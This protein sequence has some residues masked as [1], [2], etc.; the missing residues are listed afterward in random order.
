M[1]GLPHLGTPTT[2][3][4][5]SEMN[6]ARGAPYWRQRMESSLPPAPPAGPVAK[7]AEPPDHALVPALAGD[8][9]AY[10]EGS[11]AASS[12][13][14]YDAAW[15]T[16]ASWCR[17][18][19]R[20]ELPATPATVA[21]YLADR[22]RERK[23]NTVA[24][25]MAA[26]SRAHQL[27]RE[28]NPVLDPGVRAVMSGIR[29]ALG[30]APRQV[31]PLLASDV[32]AILGLLADDLTGLRDRVLLLVGL[33]AATR[34]QELVGIDVEDLA[35]ANQG[36]VVNIKTS[37]TDQERKGALVG[38]AVG[39]EPATCPVV[40]VRTWMRESGVV[41][42]P[43][44][45]EVSRHG[46]VGER[47]LRPRAVYRLVRRLGAL[48]GLDPSTLGGHSLRAGFATS[49]AMQGVPELEIAEV[50]RHRSVAVLR[51]YVRRATVLEHDLT[52]RLGL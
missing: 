6:I 19:G 37:K 13:A 21:S 16:F 3:A 25:E 2:R 52:R 48:V 1:S 22:A 4:A 35:F 34:Q 20:P 41:S 45:R 49:A 42:G 10:V 32:K 29:R 18:N 50:T 28:T 38:L 17:A 51:S 12:R 47:R 39:S 43:L 31:A 46:S 24:V 15:Q 14:R 36:M 9:A 44:L 23:V 7:V 27:V 26:I 30:I 5:R 40:A 33:L 11:L 8:V